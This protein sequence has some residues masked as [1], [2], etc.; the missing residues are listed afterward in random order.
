MHRVQDSELIT[1][2]AEDTWNLIRDLNVRPIWDETVSK[3][4]R[5]DNFLYYVAPL[6]M[7]FK[8]YWKGEYITF[9]PP[10]RSAIRMVSG[11]IIR[12][13]KSLVGTWIIT[14]SGMNT[15]LTMNISF[16]P[17]FPIPLL[18]MLMKRRVK[19]LLRKSL[20]AFSKVAAEHASK[21]Q[22]QLINKKRKRNT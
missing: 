11:S 20:S 1:I 13:F 16:E 9:D 18:G 7:G 14:P 5:D 10:S 19:K 15:M 21:W 3:V 12:P 6:L 22:T 17:R 4:E 8:W 2:S